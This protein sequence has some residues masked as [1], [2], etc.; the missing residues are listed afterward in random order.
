MNLPSELMYSQW[1]DLFFENIDPSFLSDRVVEQC[2][3]T[4][5]DW[6]ESYLNADMRPSC[7]EIIQFAWKINEKLAE[8]EA[9]ALSR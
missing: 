1:R 6:V 5:G 3:E 4:F 9:F 2:N 8:M 7:S